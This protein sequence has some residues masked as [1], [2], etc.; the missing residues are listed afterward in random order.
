[1][2]RTKAH[3]NGISNPSNQSISS[4]LILTSCCPGLPAAAASLLDPELISRFSGSF[5]ASTCYIVSFPGPV[6]TPGEKYLA[7]LSRFSV[8]ETPGAPGATQL[9]K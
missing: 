1:M 9:P 3:F 6:K 7:E 4:F 8:E 2:T 5:E